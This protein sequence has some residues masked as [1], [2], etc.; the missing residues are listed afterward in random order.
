MGEAKQVDR[1]GLT[2]ELY[3]VIE[4]R[5][6]AADPE[7]S[8]VASLFAGGSDR[9]LKKA[10]EEMVEVLIAAKNRGSEE[11]VAELADLVFHLLVMMADL[12]IPPARVRAEL[13]RRFGRSGLEEKAARRPGR[14][15]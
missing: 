7:R 4:A 3:R 12:E 9:I 5:R 15:G 1:A 14:S 8:Y 6:G 13:A 2:D 11:V 10:G